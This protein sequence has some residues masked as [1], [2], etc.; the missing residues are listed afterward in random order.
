M[1]NR[2][3]EN[4]PKE[5]LVCAVASAVSLVLS[6]TGVLKGILP[7]DIAWIAIA[8][9]GIPILV[10]AFKGVIFEHDIKADLLVSL[11][12]IASAATGE[13][14]AAGEVALIMQIGSL[15]EDYTS[16]KAKE[17]I[18]KLIKLTP[19]TARVNR[20]GKEAEIPAEEV[21][22][23][24]ML[25][26]IA[27]EIIPVDGTILTGET[28][29][30]QSVMTGESI[31]VDK[32]PGDTVSSGTLNQFGTFTMR[33]DAVST[34]SSLQRMIKLTEEAEENQAPI[35]KQADKWATWLVVIALSCAVIT[36]IATGESM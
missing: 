1:F 6:I 23:G 25:T 19:Q 11:A 8:L 4:E 14:F 15:L 7:F 13:F 10:G 3:L 20:D 26:V 28:A 18:E 33:A 27:G 32:K 22:I 17:G 35:V 2:W 31:P 30:D 12:L 16:G 21:K 24:D 36:W 29:I 5:T 9:C 34:N